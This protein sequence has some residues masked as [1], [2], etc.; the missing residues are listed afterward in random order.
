MAMW[1][2]AEGQDVVLP[3]CHGCGLLGSIN[4]GLCEKQME[5]CPS[6]VP[7]LR[8]FLGMWLRSE[9]STL[10]PS[11]TQGSLKGTFDLV[12]LSVPSSLSEHQEGCI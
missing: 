9:V 2:V 3:A 7:Y 12:T 1:L 10:H 11:G 8:K 4:L 6:H 5:D